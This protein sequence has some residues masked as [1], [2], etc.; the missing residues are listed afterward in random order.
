MGRRHVLSRFPERLIY[1]SYARL[2]LTVI[3]QDHILHQLRRAD[4]DRSGD[5]R[6]LGSREGYPGYNYVLSSPCISHPIQQLRGSSTFPILPQQAKA[7][8]NSSQVY[9]LTEII[10]GTLKLIA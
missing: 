2:K 1:E 8:A 7:I 5:P 3:L 10:G 6:L 9:G 4:S